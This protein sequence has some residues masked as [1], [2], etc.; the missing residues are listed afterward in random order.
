MNNKA[1]IIGINLGDFGSTGVIMR[2][3]LEYA[4]KHGGFDYLVIVPK[5]EGKPNTYAFLEQNSI[6]DKIDRR[7]FHRSLGNPDG[8]YEHRATKRIIHKL[9]EKCEEY[10]KVIVHLHNIHMASIDYRLLFRYLAKNNKIKN[11]FY[12]IHDAWPY[13][14]ACYCYNFINCNEWRTGCRCNCPQNYG[15]KHF[16]VNKIWKIKKKYTLLLN[17]KMIL[18]PVSNWINNEINYSFLCHF[19]RIV[20]NGETNVSKLPHRDY[21]IIERYSLHNKKVVLTVSAYW[22]DWKGY[23]YIYDVADKLPND[24]MVIVVGGKFDTTNHCN[25]IHFKDV[26][27]GELN[28]FYSIADVYMSTSQ[29]ESLGL[30]TCEAQICG[31]PVVAF[32]HGGIKETFNK[33]TG[34][35]VGEDNDIDKMV[36]AIIRVVEEHPFKKEDI[37]RNGNR[38]KKFAA[39]KKYF[40]LYNQIS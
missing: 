22:N 27:N 35:L 4:N 23:K 16:S 21:G 24:Y 36:D 14:S 1:I 32:G 11:V 33:K 39:A 17:G 15:T 26:P 5:T 31:V 40:R 10:Q 9:N 18:L 20:I 34:I 30:T 25:I 8:L 28:R 38:F 2:N 29:S 6:V 12:T 3:S 19:K 37:I 7:I 13:T